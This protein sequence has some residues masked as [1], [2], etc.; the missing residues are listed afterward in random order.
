MIGR[1]HRQLKAATGSL[2]KPTDVPVLIIPLGVSATALEARVLVE[3]AR[4]AA[5]M[6]RDVVVDCTGTE[7][8]DATA[9]QILLALRAELNASGNALR[10]IEVADSLRWRFQAV[11]LE[12]EP[13]GEVASTQS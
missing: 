13:S 8:C 9:L 11:G 1:P 6:G 3:R 4:A 12:P 5:A 7:R 2:H 10:I